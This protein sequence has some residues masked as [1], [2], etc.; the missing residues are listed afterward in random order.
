[1]KKFYDKGGSVLVPQAPTEPDERIDKMTGLPYDLQAGGAFVDEE[2]R[3]GFSAA[4]LVKII[5]RLRRSPREAVTD[6]R[7]TTRI[8]GEDAAKETLRDFRYRQPKNFIDPNDPRLNIIAV[9][10]DKEGTFVKYLDEEEGMTLDSFS[11]STDKDEIIRNYQLSNPENEFV[12][13]QYTP[14][15][16]Y[17]K[18]RAEV[19][20]RL[21]KELDDEFNA[22]PVE[23]EGIVREYLQAIPRV[24]EKPPINATLT[25]EEFLKGSKETN[26]QFHGKFFG[27][28]Q[29][30]NE[31]ASNLP[32]ELGMHIGTKGQSENIVMRR[33]NPI[34]DKLIEDEAK[35]DYMK[36]GLAKT[37]DEAAVLVKDKGVPDKIYD[38]IKE[39][40]LDSVP[41]GVDPQIREGFINVK[42]PLVLDTDM[43]NW[44]PAKFLG[45]YDPEGKL[46]FAEQAD[47]F[48]AALDAQVKLPPERFTEII[49]SRAEEINFFIRKKEM[50]SG[51]LL[52]DI[53]DY[54]INIATRS[55]LEDLGFDSIKY[56]NLGELAR[57]SEKQAGGHS[58]ILF[59]DDQFV[60]EFAEEGPIEIKLRG[61]DSPD[62]PAKAALDDIAEDFEVNPYNEREFMGD[63]AAIEL[64]Q[65]GDVLHISSIRSEVQGE[66]NASKLLDDVLRIADINQTSVTLN[67]Q[68]V[69]NSGLNANELKA[70]YHRRGFFEEADG[71]LMV[72]EAFTTPLSPIRPFDSV[73]P[74]ATYDEMYNALDKGNIKDGVYKAGKRDKINIP[75]E[76]GESVGIRLDIPA[77]TKHNTWVPTVHANK[78]RT[79]HRAT[80]YLENPNLTPSK[81]NEEQAYRIK[82]SKYFKAEIDRLASLGRLRTGFRSGD[83]NKGELIDASTKKGK[84]EIDKIKKSY[85]KTNFSRINGN[86]VN[87]TDEE[88]FRI[89]QE[90]LNSNEWTQVGFNPLRHSYYFDRATGKPVLTGDAA[91]QVG[92]LVLI[93][94]AKFGNIL[95]FKY[96][97]GGKVLRS[98]GRT[99]RAEGGK[100]LGSLHR[101]CA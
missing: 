37:E 48:V 63:G 41:T 17:Y 32:R 74:P 65:R 96:A 100:I 50:N 9:K 81:G 87:N 88:N 84:K 22:I 94:N 73:P 61:F 11:R 72:R 82:M 40:F 79:S 16:I 80:M 2:D 71:D 56:K 28:V 31:L 52:N 45:G 62:S 93:K 99:R 60:T 18:R 44:N 7:P 42:N 25:K 43:I 69:G 34:L 90:A 27:S 76:E 66:G 29:Y 13:I 83:Y 67:A 58:Y 98:L 55:M 49:N 68:P 89:A 23:D 97:T 86:L 101:H 14:Q 47:S 59:R 85:D 3:L 36:R 6:A 12:D 4:G 54:Q 78:G 8:E 26:P 91:V 51:E 33:V 5:Q 39:E 57:V 21:A 20:D 92:P 95:D 70:W 24:S 30:D 15:N 38:D 19:E 64:Q 1:M 10:P 77:Y 53:Y 75:I 35:F 46:K